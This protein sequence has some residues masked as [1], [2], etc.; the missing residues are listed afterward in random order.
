MFT[1]IV[2][3]AGIIERITP[4]PKSIAMT[5]RANVC[6]RAL[7]IGDS[8]AVNGCCLTAVIFRRAENPS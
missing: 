7:K 6:G 3:E 8:V 4:T 1:G 2:E 5:V